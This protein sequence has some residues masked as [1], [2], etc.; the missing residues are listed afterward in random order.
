MEGL[1]PAPVSSFLTVSFPHLS[2]FK[3]RHC[4]QHSKQVLSSF[5]HYFLGVPLIQGSTEME[6]GEKDWTELVNVK[7]GV[8][9]FIL[10]VGIFSQRKI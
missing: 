3:V 2:S 1:L 9:G 6:T 10:Y 7:E 4:Y 5:A 8:N